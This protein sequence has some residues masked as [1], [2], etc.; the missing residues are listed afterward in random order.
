MKGHQQ[1]PEEEI[2]LRELINV[3]LKRKWL[4]IGIFIVA[5]LIA[6]IVSFFVLKPVYEAKATLFY[7]EPEYEVTLE[8]KIRTQPLTNISLETYE[9]LIKTKAIEEQI[10]EELGLDKPPY[11]MTFLNLDRMLSLTL[12]KN[13]NLIQMK[14]NSG[15]P[16]I[17]AKIVNLWADLFVERNKYLFQQDNERASQFIEKQLN[18]AEV[19]LIQTED[20]IR[21]FNATNQVDILQKEI[22]KTTENIVKNQSKIEDLNVSLSMEKNK[23]ARLWQQLI[24]SRTAY[25]NSRKANLQMV[26]EQQLAKLTKLEELLSGMEDKIVLSKSI[27]EDPYFE[28]LLQEYLK[29]SYISSYQLN[30]NLASEEINPIYIQLTEDKNILEM[31]I[32][33]NQK[34]IEILDKILVFLSKEIESV[35]NYLQKNIASADSTELI[36]EI[37][38]SLIRISEVDNNIGNE[39]MTITKGLDAIESMENEIE[40]LAMSIGEARDSIV[41][42][43]DELANQELIKARLD[44]K[45]KNENNIFDILTQ[46]NEEIKIALS[47]ESAN[48]E[49]AKYAFI[50]Q[51]PIKPNKKLNIAIGG[52]LGLFMGIFLAF[53]IEFWQSSNK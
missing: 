36:N 47:A 49:V 24:Q 28:S 31:G 40:Q 25:Y 38:N 42:L 29:D 39:Y 46:K 8:P 43:K 13:S 34:E 37:N 53:F 7:H 20:E 17:A 50:P 51:N 9:H 35:N 27:M 23:A 12:I 16:E 11:E 48:L 21:K 5:V 33:D 44:R 30:L 14:I 2:D 4:I 1:M 10:I 45:Y 19:V 32:A 22:S 18:E 26:R 41:N 15:D 52:V 6:G 3:L